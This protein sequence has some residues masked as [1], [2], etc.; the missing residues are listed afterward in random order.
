MLGHRICA[1]VIFKIILFPS[2]L[3]KWL[4][5]FVLS[6][7]VVRLPTGSHSHQHL[8]LSD[9]FILGNLLDEQFTVVIL[10]GFNFNLS[11]YIYFYWITSS[12]MA[13]LVLCDTQFP[14]Y[15]HTIAF[16]LIRAFQIILK[17]FWNFLSKYYFIFCWI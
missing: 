2:L 13:I 9:F 14:L 5:W 16:H 17:K 15:E 7:V 1:C 6:P 4:Y 12:E 10:N 11:L 3:P 8:L